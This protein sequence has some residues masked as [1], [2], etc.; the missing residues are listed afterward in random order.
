MNGHSPVGFSRTKLVDIQSRGDDVLVAHGYI[1]DHIYTMSV[2]V[3]FDLKKG[4]ISA[5]Q[6]DMIRYTSVG[7]AE[8]ESVFG[9]AVGITF[10]PDMDSRIKKTVGRAGCRHVAAVLVDCCH[11]A[12]RALIAREMEKSKVSAGEALETVKTRHP[13]LDY[14]LKSV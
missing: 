1:T 11:A 6:G 2:D 7:C 10:G 5:I 14:L 13:Y 9:D 12:P 3:E 4:A 8:A